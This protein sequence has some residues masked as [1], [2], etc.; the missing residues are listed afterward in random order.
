MVAPRKSAARGLARTRFVLEQ[1]PVVLGCSPDAGLRLDGDLAADSPLTDC[2]PA[3]DGVA[4]FHC[5]LEAYHQ[6]IRVRDLGSPAGTRLNGAL[7]RESLVR[8]GDELTVGRATFRVLYDA[9]P[10]RRPPRIV[11]ETI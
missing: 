4:P 9:V 6:H 7:I 5:T 2:S 1:L 3:D 10:R 11:L 8:S